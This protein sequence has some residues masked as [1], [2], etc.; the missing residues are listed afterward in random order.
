MGWDGM[1]TTQTAIRCGTVAFLDES[2]ISTGVSFLLMT[3]HCRLTEDEL[4]A[5]ALEF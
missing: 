3:I 1:G 4:A 5:A 2:E